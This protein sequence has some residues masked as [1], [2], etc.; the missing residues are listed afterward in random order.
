VIGCGGNAFG[1][2]FKRLLL[3]AIAIGRRREDL[4]DTT[5]QQY[6]ADLDRRRDRILAILPAT[7]AGKTLRKRLAK[8]R[9]D[10]FLFVTDR[11]VPYT[12]NVAE[13]NLRPSVVPQGHQRVQVGL[14]Y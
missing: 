4:K 6:Q 3:R 14:G 1:T 11:E 12:N 13:R 9:A 2:A 8:D 10:L 5:L 7:K